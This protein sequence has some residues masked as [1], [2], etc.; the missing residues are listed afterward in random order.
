MQLEVERGAQR[1]VKHDGL[2][3]PQHGMNTLQNNP[4]NDDAFKKR[5]KSELLGTILLGAK[6]TKHRA[7]RQREN[8]PVYC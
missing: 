5:E 7:G 3:Q 8:T 1:L 6:G 2:P 4:H